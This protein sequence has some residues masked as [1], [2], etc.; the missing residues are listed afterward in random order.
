MTKL[1]LIIISGVPYGLIIV[2]IYYSACS[3]NSAGGFTI[4]GLCVMKPQCLSNGKAVA[5]RHHHT[6]LQTPDYSMVKSC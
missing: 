2:L 4:L 1:G 5:K 6:E 3:T